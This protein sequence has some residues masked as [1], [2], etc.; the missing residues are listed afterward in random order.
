MPQQIIAI[1]SQKLNAIQAC[2]RKYDLSFNQHLEPVEKAE[3]LEKGDLMH[4]MMQYYYRLVQ[5]RTRWSQNGHSHEDIINIVLRIA[6]HFAA[7]MDLDLDEC[8]QMKKAFTEYARYYEDEMVTVLAVE[9]VGSKVLYEDEDLKIIYE[10]KIDLV[11]ALKNLPVIWVD[12]KTS[13]RRREPSILSNQ[14]MG[15]TWMLGTNN[16]I[17]NKIGLQ[18]TLKP[19]EKFQ[20]ATLSFPND[21]IAEWRENSVWWIKMLCFHYT[22]NFW[23]P[24]FTSCDKYSGCIFKGI[25]ESERAA[26][27]FRKVRD[28]AVRETPWDPG[29]DL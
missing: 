1:D 11:I 6:D 24:N 17:V 16:G 29:E 23:P 19:N 14:F 15:Y 9:E 25:C 7:K 8:E 13:S 10:T 28:F 22:A 20:R 18:K 27:Q 2:A 12:H 4:K 3:A 21:V 26:R 5:H